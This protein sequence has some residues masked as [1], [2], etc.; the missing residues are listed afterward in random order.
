[1]QK[2]KIQFKAGLTLI[3][4]L[5]AISVLLISVVGPMVIYSRNISD[6]RFAG[7]QTTAY[8][9]AQEAI[10]FVKYR[11]YTNLNNNVS[12]MSGLNNCTSGGTCKVDTVNDNLCWNGSPFCDA[13]IKLDNGIYNSSSGSNTIFKRDL[14]IVDGGNGG[15][16]VIV[17]STVYWTRLGENKNITVTENIFR[18]QP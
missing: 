10:E 3:E 16:E 1:M 13:F 17:T 7:N 15:N 5:V 4:T 8:Y 6:A 14:S 11:V 18:W 12:W 9:L 2:K